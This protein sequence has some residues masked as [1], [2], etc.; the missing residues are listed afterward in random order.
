MLYCIYWY[1]CWFVDCIGRLPRRRCV[2]VN[3]YNVLV[4]KPVRA[5]TDD[6]VEPLILCCFVWRSLQFFY[7]A[8]KNVNYI[9]GCTTIANSCVLR[10]TVFNWSIG[11]RCVYEHTGYCNVSAVKPFRAMPDSHT[12]VTCVGLF[13][14]HG[15]S[16]RAWTLNKKKIILQDLKSAGFL[17]TSALSAS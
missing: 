2:L 10:F 12:C 15:V 13:V 6:V 11:H 14:L 7:S 3:A 17:Y 8:Y 9:I 5:T 1:C 16:C 4:D